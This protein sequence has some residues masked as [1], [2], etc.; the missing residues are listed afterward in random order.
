MELFKELYNKRREV[1]TAFVIG[2]LGHFVKLVNYL[3]CSDSMY[4]IENTWS[5]MSTFGRWFSGVSAI[6]LSGRADLQWVEGVVS[7]FF[8]SLTI[9]TIL[10]IFRVR[11]DILRIIAITLFM[12]FPSVTSTMAFMVWSA[13]YALAYFLAIYALYLC[14][15]DG[16]NI[17]RGAAAVLC[18]T[19]SGGI[20]QIYLTT[21]AICFI[22][23]IV[24]RLLDGCTVRSLVKPVLVTGCVF[25]A[26]MAA[27]YII[28]K[29]V[30]YSLGKSLS[31]YQGIASSGNINHYI[32]RIALRIIREKLAIFYFGNPGFTAYRLLN[33]LLIP[34]A[35]IG[36]I[37]MLACRKAPLLNRIL[38]VPLL[39]VTP[40]AGYAF[41]FISYGV[42]YH[43]VMEGGNYFLY[44]GLILLLD[45]LPAERRKTFAAVST[46]LGLLCIY[47]WYNTNTA[48][49]QMEITY[50]RSAFTAM[51]IVAKI[52]TVPQTR[53]V[54][55]VAWCGNPSIPAPAVNLNPTMYGC[56][57]GNFVY[58]SFHF[59]Q[60]VDYY[61]GRDYVPVKDAV[62]EAIMQTDAYKQMD[63]YPYGDYVQVIDGITV[64]KLS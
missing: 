43:T 37:I 50:Q 54:K 5:G 1:L 57:C 62:A 10:H 22:Y 11:S 49:K 45:A 32:I 46:L 60:F 27:Y 19:L 55:S 23:Y 28:G 17:Y 9:L 20:Y 38:C 25:L 24:F 18:V 35:V 44:F 42:F 47:H 34:I 6:L 56:D 53:N 13:S 41:Q 52:D 21:A 64:I 12:L 63:C 39:L 51:E 8:L 29:L 40:I 61:L 4:V 7:I 58:S 30:L 14:I 3:P 48:Y 26:G 16:F 36:W 2:L 33:Y 15:S 59:C 31:D